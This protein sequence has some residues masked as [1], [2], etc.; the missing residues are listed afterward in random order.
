M[1]KTDMHVLFCLFS[2][3]SV[4]RMEIVAKP[5][6]SYWLYLQLD[7]QQLPVLEV[8][9][10]PKEG[11]IWKGNEHC[12]G[13]HHKLQ[14]SLQPQQL[15]CFQ[16]ISLRLL[17]HPLQ[18]EITYAY[19]TLENSVHIGRGSQCEICCLQPY[20]SMQH[21][22]IIKKADAWYIQDDDSRNGVYVNQQRRCIQKLNCGD[23]IQIVGL[24]IIFGDGFLMVEE[25]ADIV[26]QGLS[27]FEANK[28]RLIPQEI[29]KIEKSRMHLP[30]IEAFS[31]VVE[32]PTI[33][34]QAKQ[35]PV[36]IVLGPSM[37]MGISSIV[38][39]MAT[40]MQA[41]VLKQSIWQSMPSLVMA[42]SMA[43]SS[44][45]WPLVNRYFEKYQQKKK[46]QDYAKRYQNY[47]QQKQQSINGYIATLKDAQKV[48]A[49]LWQFQ[50]KDATVLPV[51]YLDSEMDD[52]LLLLL[53]SGDQ[54]FRLALQYQKPEMQLSDSSSYEAFLNF[55][56]QEEQ[57]MMQPLFY[58]LKKHRCLGIWGETSVLPTLA[59]LAQLCMLH[60]PTQL[61]LILFVE[62]AM[63]RDWHLRFLPHLFT[64]TGKRC[65]FTT[66]QQATLIE[67]V[68][69]QLS[70]EDCK[71]CVMISFYPK[72]RILLAMEALMKR[73]PF[74]YFI[75][76][77]KEKAN[78]MS[79]FD[80]LLYLPEKTMGYL[81]QPYQTTALHIPVISTN[82][83]LQQFQALN[84]Y[85]K[86]TFSHT[87]TIGFL[88]LY[89]CGNVNQLALLNRWKQHKNERSLAVVIGRDRFGEDI[90]LDAHEAHHGPHGLIAGMTGS[91]K[92]ELL[93]TY[94][95][96]L[97][98][99]YSC[100]EVSFV[101]IDYKGGMMA[102]AFRKL[103]HIAYILTNLETG[104][105]HRFME[106]LDHE[107]KHRQQL[108]KEVKE[109]F[110]MAAVDMDTYQ[111]LYRQGKLSKPLAHLFLVADE[112]A[113]L[114]AQQ[115]TF[116]EQLKQAARIGRSLGIHLLLATQKPYG[117]IDDQIWSNARFHICLK[118]Q[119]RNDS[120]DMLKKEDA[121]TLQQA[122]AFY[123]QVGNDEVFLKGQ[124]SWTQMPYHPEDMY[125]PPHT[126]DVHWYDEQLQLL[127]TKRWEEPTQKVITQLDAICRYIS[128]Q[129]QYGH[130]H[131]AFFMH[132]VLES[133][134]QNTLCTSEVPEIG[135]ADDVA[136]RQQRAFLL[137]LFQYP[138]MLVAG[139]AGSG[140]QMLI[141]KLVIE[142]AR[143]YDAINTHVYVLDGLSNT[144][145][146]LA[147]FD[148][149][150]N[151]ITPKEEE[152]VESFFYQLKHVFLQ[153]E[154]KARFLFI[155]HGY[156]QWMESYPQIEECISALFM[157]N[158]NFYILLTC[159]TPSLLP[160]RLLSQCN[161][162]Y[163]LQL[164]D[165]NEYRIVFE[166]ISLYPLM[167]EGSGIFQVD[168][169]MLLFQVNPYTELI[170]KELLTQQKHE[171]KT[172]TIPILP[173]RILPKF[174]EDALYLGKDI[175]SKQ[176]CW[177]SI[178][179]ST[180]I[181]LC[182]AFQEDE[183]FYRY[184]Q[185]WEKCYPHK[186]SNVNIQEVPQYKEGQSQDEISIL[187]LTLH[188]L[189][190]A[191]VESWFLKLLYEGD[192]LWIGKG[193][194]ESA[195][196]LKL[197]MECMQ[198][199]LKEDEALWY[200]KGEIRWIKM[201]E[202]VTHG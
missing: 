73:Y 9:Y 158:T 172:F 165:M 152:Y 135:R 190:E 76:Q 20:V 97:C 94:I 178:Q 191:Q 181:L 45:V 4:S 154:T 195:H 13:E 17:L 125:R 51:W 86:T 19:Y 132:P 34:E 5:E 184:L 31:L 49:A 196:L 126:N 46:C 175:E 171:M 90:Y 150:A 161:A 18:H 68:L 102:G 115:P 202:D 59:I 57:V 37:T 146:Y 26:M 79:V 113:E 12:Y 24:Q 25:L 137:P 14:G 23:V 8:I 87:V 144:L 141:E 147:Q 174:K 66:M 101:L 85:Q 189:M 193:I 104:G 200:R 117:V 63:S 194:A 169:R 136:Q 142:C 58:D 129:S 118:V 159:H 65:L 156:E 61:Q 71:A 62:E 180:Y 60:D 168:G 108:F 155:L 185:Q 80:N 121:C 120:I 187:F 67:G 93:M 16:G 124:S 21:A 36:W 164:A 133:S 153:M 105:M 179:E 139:K 140:K 35:I 186:K 127:G 28:V 48:K 192:I 201:A 42:V 114:K 27:L 11:W 198:K 173:K 183:G 98:V 33:M 128:K 81:Q 176:D 39:G 177:I 29:L 47:L 111:R 130:Y 15:Y 145:G 69:Q 182:R 82:L 103:P 110:D 151:V 3:D 112:F 123:L 122:G 78:L 30:V 199:E 160:Y 167:Q 107:L 44:I 134:Q 64:S 88:D 43:L 188:S 163:L 92:S 138:H 83:L 40:W 106:A 162:N 53:G 89:R 72:K 143:L 96:S 109:R 157:K 32:P 6:A 38:M 166:D 1:K 75:Q 100:E 7:G 70:L 91:G 55:L 10:K 170:I 84:L 52:F 41:M 95:L 22:S 2:K 99:C 148:V 197:P 54:A 119:E 50:K 56:K 77:D 131:K 116:M 74:L 149:V